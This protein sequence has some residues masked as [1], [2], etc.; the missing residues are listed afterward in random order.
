MSTTMQN[1]RLISPREIR[2]FMDRKLMPDL[3]KVGLTPSNGPFVL[4]IYNEEGISQTELSYRLNVDKALTTRTVRHLI[5]KGYVEDRSAD[6]HRYSLYA[7]EKG[8]E[9]AKIVEKA[10]KESWEHIFSRLEE[11]EVSEFK[12][13]LGKIGEFVREEL[14]RGSDQ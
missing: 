11:N 6:L 4:E 10:V 8:V 5:E 7:T 9:A 3:F 13:T 12:K 1:E 14:K 2:L